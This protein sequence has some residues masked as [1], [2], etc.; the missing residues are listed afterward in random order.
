[1]NRRPPKSTRTDTLFP[2]TTL[3]R[4]HRPA[5]ERR[6]V[7]GDGLEAE[8]PRPV[9]L[10]GAGL[11]LEGQPAEHQREGDQG[12]ADHAPEQAL[13]PDPPDPAA[14]PDEA[15]PEEL[16]ADGPGPQSRQEIGNASGRERVRRYV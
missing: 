15:L 7:E 6:G 5:E 4:S 1:M 13:V 12:G 2:Y 9:R 8:H 14:A 10:G 11:E 16:A 3:F